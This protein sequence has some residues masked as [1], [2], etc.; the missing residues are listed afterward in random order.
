MKARNTKAV[1]KVADRY[2]KQRG[3]GPKKVAPEKKA[4]SSRA[5]KPAPKKAEA[6]AQ[7]EESKT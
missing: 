2:R 1:E 6:T 5:R 4:A 3:L 7:V